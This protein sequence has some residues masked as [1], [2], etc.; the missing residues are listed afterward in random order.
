MVL[1][2]EKFRQYGW[3][4]CSN[5]IRSDTSAL[6]ALAATRY[7][8]NC[9]FKARETST[10]STL[11]LLESYHTLW[12]QAFFFSHVQTTGAHW[13]AGAVNLL[14][15]TACCI[16]N[17]QVETDALS[18]FNLMLML[19]HDLFEVR[20]GRSSSPRYNR[21][22]WLGVKHRVTDSDDPHKLYSWNV[23]PVFGAG[24]S[25]AGR[26]SGWKA[27]RKYWRRFE[28][29]VRKGFFSHSRFPLSCPYSPRVQSPASTSVRTLTILNNP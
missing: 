5:L 9:R 14:W 2:H 3:E 22:G 12:L 6:N 16:W 18:H 27:W 21:T 7:S 23:R 13:L 19:T 15:N 10:Y 24:N 29:Q 4:D 28:S 1:I 25:T 8:R 11:P 17:G 20:F 26:A